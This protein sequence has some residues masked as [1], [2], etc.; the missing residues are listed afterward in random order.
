MAALRTYR[1]GTAHLDAYLEDY[2]Y[3]A[4]GLIETHE[5]GGDERYLLAAVRLAER[6]LA[7]FVDEQ[8]EDSSRRRSGT[9]H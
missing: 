6:I 2:A 4:E 1:T 8:Q 9:K 7:D 3:F 5:A